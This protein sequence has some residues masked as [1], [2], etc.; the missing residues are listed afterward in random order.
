MVVTLSLSTN[1]RAVP[2]IQVNGALQFFDGSITI[3]L[4]RVGATVRRVVEL[5]LARL[6]LS[7]QTLTNFNRWAQVDFLTFATDDL[8][9]QGVAELLRVGSGPNVSITIRINAKLIQR[10]EEFGLKF[11]QSP[12]GE[13]TSQGGSQS[14]NGTASQTGN[15][16][17]ETSVAAL[18]ATVKI[19]YAAALITDPA[20]K[21]KVTDDLKRILNL[22]NNERL[23][24]LNNLLISTTGDL[25][26]ASEVRSSLA[27]LTEN[28]DYNDNPFLLLIKS[29]A[30]ATEY[31]MR[32]GPGYDINANVLIAETIRKTN[33]SFNS[34]GLTSG[35]AAFINRQLSILYH[36]LGDDEKFQEREWIARFYGASN[37]ELRDLNEGDII[38]FD[39]MP[40]VGQPKPLSKAE[41]ELKQERENMQQ[42]RKIWADTDKI[43]SQVVPTDHRASELYQKPTDGFETEA[44]REKKDTSRAKGLQRTV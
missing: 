4:P 5:V 20:L 40:S 38:E 39:V 11:A 41:Q 27:Y 15:S 14:G 17:S 35:E 28:A 7:G 37:E 18:S 34:N 36:Q 29:N 23:L 9:R 43:G 25:K 31:R 12:T 2:S 6:G 30:A 42:Q 13:F 16:Q 10:L 21:A 1:L 22:S 26:A 32:S 44:S 33:S 3:T 24:G 19:A 8:T